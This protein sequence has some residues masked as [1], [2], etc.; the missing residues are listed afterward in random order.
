MKQTSCAN[1]DGFLLASSDSDFWGLIKSLPSAH[2][3]VLLEKDKYGTYL[4]EA[5]DLNHISYCLMDQFTGNTDEIKIGALDRSIRE[6][7]AEHV[8]ITLRELVEDMCEA[9]RV[10]MTD[11]QKENYYNRLTQKQSI[12]ISEG[13]LTLG[14]K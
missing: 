14:V 4:T 12:K 13:T 10:N 7:L 1:I 5:F 11:K 6:Y 3:M 2:F 9:L 8:Q